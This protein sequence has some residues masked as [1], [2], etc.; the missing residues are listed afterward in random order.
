MQAGAHR[1]LYLAKSR[2]VPPFSHIC[3]HR[4]GCCDRRKPLKNHGHGTEN[5][6]M[7]DAAPRKAFLS[8]DLG[9]SLEYFVTG[10]LRA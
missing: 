6:R 10:V 7:C 8:R 1:G 3:F 9:P 2:R 5:L 4:G